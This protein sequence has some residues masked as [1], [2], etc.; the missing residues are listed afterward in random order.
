MRSMRTWVAA[1]AAV[2][3]KRA[4]LPTPASPETTGAPRTAMPTAGA[5]A[6]STQRGG[7]TSIPG[8]GA[9]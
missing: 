6:R 7:L 9:G 2:G 5:K 4:V 3:S 8:S 1:R